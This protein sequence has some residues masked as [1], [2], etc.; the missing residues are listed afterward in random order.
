MSRRAGVCGRATAALLLAV[1]VASVASAQDAQ[2][3]QVVTV[4]PEDKAGGLKRFWLGGGL[5]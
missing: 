3:T 2:G 4:G 1:T 5:P